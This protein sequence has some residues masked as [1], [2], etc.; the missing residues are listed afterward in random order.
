M[1]IKLYYVVTIT[2]ILP[3]SGYDFSLDPWKIFTVHYN[4]KIFSIKFVTAN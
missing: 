3:C 1:N 4:L 2:V